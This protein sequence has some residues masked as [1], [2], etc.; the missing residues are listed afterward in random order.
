MSSLAVHQVHS[1]LMTLTMKA[2][3]TDMSRAEKMD[4]VAEVMD[5]A[6]M[7]QMIITIIGIGG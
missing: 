7:I 5:M 3:T 4:D 1:L 2:T 6:M